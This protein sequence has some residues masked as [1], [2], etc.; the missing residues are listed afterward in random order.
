MFRQA[1]SEGLSNAMYNVAIDKFRGVKQPPNGD[2]M[3]NGPRR[4]EYM[5]GMLEQQAAEKQMQKF[6]WLAFG[7]AIGITGGLV[8][9]SFF[10]RR[11]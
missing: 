7:V 3:F 5:R 1:V 6:V 8:L 10:G 11:K 9:F 4:L 2:G